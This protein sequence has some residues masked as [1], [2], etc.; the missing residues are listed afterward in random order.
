MWACATGS[1]ARTTALLADRSRSS[2]SANT[3]SGR[4][5]HLPLLVRHMPRAAPHP[6]GCTA[7]S[8]S[9]TAEMACGRS[10]FDPV[11]GDPAALDQHTAEGLARHHLPV[12]HHPLLS[13]APSTTCHW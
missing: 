7:M 10:C 12:A 9:P 8:H 5:Q 13:N 4:L 1:A 6:P 11:V 2:I 3:L